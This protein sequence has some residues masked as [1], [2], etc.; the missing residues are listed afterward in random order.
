[1]ANNDTT[2]VARLLHSLKGTSGLYGLKDISQE[3][4]KA[5]KL[6]N[7]PP[8][9]LE[10]LKE[11]TQLTQAHLK[12]DP[13]KEDVLD[14][15]GEISNVI[16]GSVRANYGNNFNISVPIVF[17]GSPKQLKFPQDVAVFVIPMKW[18]GHEA[19][20]VVGLE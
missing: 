18:K 13:K 16:A 15:A 19:F 20:L 2:E 11:I 7:D 8:L 10:T 6:I 4:R 9:L 17:E 14:M 5:E 1:M 12:D 3:A